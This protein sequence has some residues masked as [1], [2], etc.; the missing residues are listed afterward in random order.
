MATDDRTMVRS[1]PLLVHV[2]AGPTSQVVTVSGRINA[3]TLG[4]LR[5]LLHQ[6]VDTGT[7]DIV[8]MLG[9][10]EIGDVS[11]L[12]MLVG[13]HHRARRAGRRLVVAQASPRTARLLRM[14]RLDRVLGA[15]G[16]PARAPVVPLTAYPRL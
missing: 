5:D 12:G 8:L 10:A 4:A 11:A 6:V 14:S 3:S 1:A 13:A 2:V 7:G 16:D 9:D 15:P